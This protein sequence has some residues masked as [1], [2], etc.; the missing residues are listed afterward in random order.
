LLHDILH[1]LQRVS[2]HVVCS[3]LSLSEAGVIIGDSL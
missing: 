3:P 1:G 2:D